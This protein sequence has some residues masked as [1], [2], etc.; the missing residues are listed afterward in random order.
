VVVAQQYPFA[1]KQLFD[2]LVEKLPHKNAPSD[3]SLLYYRFLFYLLSRISNYEEAVLQAV[4][5][6]LCQIDGDIKVRL[7][8]HMLNNKIQDDKEI[9]LGLLMGELFSYM[10]T[11]L[12]P[13]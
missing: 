1:M 13:S 10:R 5:D 7:P 3:V 4:I 2:L 6:K 9:K 8:R 11:R 12:Q